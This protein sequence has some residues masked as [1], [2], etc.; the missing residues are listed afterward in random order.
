VTPA[1]A[2]LGHIKTALQQGAELLTGGGKPEGLSKGYFVGEQLHQSAFRSHTAHAASSWAHFLFAVRTH[3][4]TFCICAEPTV[5]RVKRDMKI[6]N[7]E[8]FGPVLSVMT[9]STEAE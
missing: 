9:F 8:V 1:C 2:V 4:L 6:W 3:I 7:T 5:L